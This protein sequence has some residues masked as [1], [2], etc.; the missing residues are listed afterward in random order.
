[1]GE[2][3]KLLFYGDHCWEPYFKSHFDESIGFGTGDTRV[4]DELDRQ[5]MVLLKK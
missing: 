2:D 1:M 4:L 3:D 5:M